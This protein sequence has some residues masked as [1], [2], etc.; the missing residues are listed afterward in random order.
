M[1]NESEKSHLSS[2]EPN[3]GTGTLPGMPHRFSLL[4]TTAI[5]THI[6]LLSL[7]VRTLKPR[8]VEQFAHGHSASKEQT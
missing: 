1:H 4:L 5:E 8:E 7:K 3:N 6:L 2:S